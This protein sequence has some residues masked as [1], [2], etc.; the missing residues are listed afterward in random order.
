VCT[1]CS[2]TLIPTTSPKPIEGPS[3]PLDEREPLWIRLLGWLEGKEW[4]WA[5][6]SVACAVLA[7][8]VLG[9]LWYVLQAL[10]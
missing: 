3:A 2:R 9:L 7:I 6:V 4:V 10:R 1:G 8:A 5:I